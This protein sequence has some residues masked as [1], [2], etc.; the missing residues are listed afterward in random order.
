MRSTTDKCM[1]YTVF[2]TYILYNVWRNIPTVCIGI[3]TYIGH[4]QYGKTAN[5]PPRVW[6]HK[7][8]AYR[9]TPRHAQRV[10]NPRPGS[11]EPTHS[12]FFLPLGSTH[13]DGSTLSSLV[14]Q[15]GLSHALFSSSGGWQSA[16]SLSACLILFFSG[17][18]GLT[19]LY[20]SSVSVG[21]QT[22]TLLLVLLSDSLVH[23]FWFCRVKVLYSFSGSV[24]RNLVLF[25]W[26]S[27]VS[28]HLLVLQPCTLPLVLQGDSL[29]HSYGS[30]GPGWQFCSVLYASSGSE[31]DSP[32]A[33]FIGLVRKLKST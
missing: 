16:S 20:S 12:S 19:D 9:F 2:H 5:C 11:H 30:A 14:L 29:R 26:F 33:E 22:C 32:I 21:W 13:T 28:N 7:V 10:A 8:V 31:G 24:G 3:H 23:F 15:K 17:S 4:L 18:V 1:E 25:L 6:H 27:Q